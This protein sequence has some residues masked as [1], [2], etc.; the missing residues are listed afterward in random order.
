MRRVFS[1]LLV[2]H[3]GLAACSSAETPPSPAAVEPVAAATPAPTVSVPSATPTAARPPAPPTAT[4]P[5]ATATP[6]PLPT[7]QIYIVQEYDTLLGLAVEF[8]TSVEALAAANGISEEDFL[9]IGQELVI[10][11]PAEEQTPP[12]TAE[13]G[14]TAGSGEA[15][16]DTAA[17]SPAVLTPTEAPTSTES[18]TGGA[19]AVVP[20]APPP[21]PSGPPLPTVT[22]DANINPLTGLPVDDPAKLLRRP[23]LV[24]IGNDVGARLSQVGFNSADLVYEEI[25]EWWVT[26]F[27]AIFLAETPNTVGPVRSA[28]L[29]NVQLAPQ[30][31]GALAHSGGSDP[32]RWEISQ[33]PIANLD[34]YYNPSPY[35]Y[36]PNEGWQ[37]R[38][39]IDTGAARDY[40]AAQGLD[41]AVALPGFVF[42]DSLDQGEPGENIFIPYPRATSFTQWSYDPTSGQYLRW[43]DGAPLADVSRGQV[44]ASNVIVYFAEH[45]ETDIVEDANG[46]TSIR[47]LVNGKGPAWFFRDGKLTKGFWQTD[48]SRTPYFGYQDGSPYPLKPGNTWVEVV[49][50]YY[51][52]GLN[53]PDE[54]SA[55]P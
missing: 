36:R 2:I 1:L 6:S 12:P 44:T 24:R 40:M 46:A 37:T 32:V 3:L 35:F 38:L 7:P 51:K 27:T 11:V 20:P 9:Q 17:A 16:G 8:D 43:I 41:A 22:H 33:A 21:T 55:T 45:Q 50:T 5:P 10:P 48:G 42:S 47:I 39:A 4:A 53:G 29:I 19:P 28:R 18:V 54:A 26:R 49:P 13:P 25:T 31:Q 30:Y 15:A 14:V 34:E 23:L 52:I